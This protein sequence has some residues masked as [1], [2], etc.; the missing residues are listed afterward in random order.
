MTEFEDIARQ[1]LFLAV[2][3]TQHRQIPY[4]EAW[5][6]R[7]LYIAGLFAGVALIYFVVWPTACVLFSLE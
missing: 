6:D 3:N 4:S 7:W 2:D 1:K 5:V